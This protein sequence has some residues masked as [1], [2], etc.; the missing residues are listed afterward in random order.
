VVADRSATARSTTRGRHPSAPSTAGRPRPTG[1][2]V[3]PNA[4]PDRRKAGSPAGRRAG[5]PAA[6]RTPAGTARPATRR[7]SRLAQL[8]TAP[9]LALLVGLL[10]AFGLIM[11][12]SASPLISM[13]LYGSPWSILIRQSMWMGVGIGGL[14]VCARIDYRKWRAAR[15]VL[16]VVTMGLLVVVLV[17]HLG[18]SAGGSSRWIGVGMLQLQPSELMKLALA[19]FA[20]DLLTRREQWSDPKMIIVPVVSVLAISGVLILKQPDMGTALVLCCIAFGIL[21]MGGVPMGPIVKILG[22]FAVLAVVVGLADP[23]RRDRILSFL[24]PG[25]NRSGTGYQVWQ[26]LIGLGS[27]HLFG[28]GLGGGRE[29]WGTLPNAHTDFIFSV[30]GE[31]LGLVGAVVL[32]GMF[33]AL[34]WYGLRAAIR[35]PDRFGSLLAVGITTWITSQAVINIGAVIG[36]LPVTGIPLPFISFGGSSL[37]ITLA[38]VGILLNIAA[39][40]R[41]AALTPLRRRPNHR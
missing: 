38:A 30:V 1:A 11:V 3:E 33:F 26:S 28:L 37:I 40:E 41:P 25:A 39:H 14:L 10:C 13:S 2:P 8:G 36:V 15:G 21:F 9:V 27:G 18:V 19:V 22:A 12:G 16:V 17:P 7:G 6:A 29:K 34:A 4:A 24:N 5:S 31:E 20:A 32:L 23:Y 35:A